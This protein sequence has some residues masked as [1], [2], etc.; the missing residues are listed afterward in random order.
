MTH[1]SVA[2][3]AQ[4]LP[5]TSPEKYSSETPEQQ[6]KHKE[7]ALRVRRK[8]WHGSKRGLIPNLRKRELELL[9]VERWGKQLPDDDAG[10]ADLRLM[11]DHL[12][13]LGKNHITAWV[14]VWAPWL[15]DD[16]LDGLIALVGPGKHW[17]ANALAKELNLDDATRTR[18]DIRTIGAVD[19]TKAK[20]A[21]RCKKRK[22]AAE[23]ARR[24]KAGA[25]SHATSA[26]QL[27]PWI[28]LGYSESTYYRK[29]R[30]TDSGD[31]NSCHILLESQCGTNRCH[32]GPSPEAATPWACAA[33]DDAPRSL[34]FDTVST[35]RVERVF[36][37]I[38]TDIP[39]TKRETAK[40]A[41]FVSNLRQERKAESPPHA[42]RLDI[43]RVA[44]KT[45][46]GATDLARAA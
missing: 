20:R 21:K 6:A 35:A 4:E 9:F 31:S 24:A 46:N 38:E 7:I 26:A 10:R 41:R 40:A 32:G 29:K 33:A 34:A 37:A 28:A 42:A 15:T 13:Q 39:E 17:K 45:A 44:A 36:P 1:R 22:T 5:L 8:N 43:G 25:A 3:V 16:E 11:A 30:W 2:R 27:K 14:N 19:R 12:A 18:L 23:A